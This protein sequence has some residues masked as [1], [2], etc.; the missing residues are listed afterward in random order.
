M[1]L[2]KINGTTAVVF[3]LTVLVGTTL[4]AA[5]TA[6]TPPQKPLDLKPR[7]IADDKTVEYDYDIV[8]VRAPRFVKG[9]D[10]KQQPAEVWPGTGHPFNLCTATDLMLLHPDGSEEVLVA[11]GKGAIADSYVSFDA[12]WVYYTYF[13]DPSLNGPERCGGAD[14]YKVHVKTRKVVRLTQQ[15]FT[16]NTGVADWSADYQ[17]PEK[18]KTHLVQRVINMNPCPLPGGRLA[19]VS[20]RDGFKTPRGSMHEAL[21]LFVMDD[22]GTNVEKIG[23]LNVAGALHPVVLKDGRLIFSSFE[24]MGMRGYGG[25]SSRFAGFWGLW[26]IHPDG[27]NWAPLV[28][29]YRNPTSPKTANH[30][31]TQL[32]DGSVV[33]GNYYELGWTGFGTYLKVPPQAPEGVP[34]FGPAKPAKTTAG[35]TYWR[36]GTSGT[37]LLTPFNHGLVG[38]A[39]AKTGHVTHPCGAPDNHLLTVWSPGGPFELFNVNGLHGGIYLIKNGQ[40]VW[41]PGAMLLIKHDPN[42]HAQWPRPLV[43]YKRV[44]GVDEPQRLADQRNDGKLSKHLPEGTPFGLVGSSSMYK[45]ESF[46]EGQV[47]EGSVTATGD[48]YAVFPSSASPPGTRSM[49]W[50][51]QNGLGRLN[52]QHQGADAGLYTNSDIHAIRILALEPA[53]I[54][55][56][57]KFFNRAGERLR[58]LGEIPVRKFKGEPGRVSAGRQP[59]DPDGNPD[60]S[61]LARIP[62]DMAWTFQT[63]DKDGMVLNMAQTWHQL[64]PGEIRTNCGGCHAHSQKPTLFEDTAAAR[65]DYPVFDLTKSTPLLTAKKNDQSGKKWDTQDTTGLRFVQGVHNVEYYRDIQPIFE[66]SCVACHSGKSAQPAV[67]LILDD[68]KPVGGTSAGPLPATYRTLNRSN[69]RMEAEDTLDTNAKVYIWHFRS[70]NSPLVWKIFGR[71]TDGLPEKS[72]PVPDGAAKHKRILDLEGDFKG[73]IMPPPEAVAGT[74]EGP[75]GKK[76]K[77][78]PLTDEDRR[79]IVRWIDLGSPIDRDYDPKNPQKLGR[80]WMLDDQRPTLT[81]TYPKVGVNEPLKRLLVGMHDYGTGLDLDSFKVVADFSIDGVPAGENLAKKFKVLP[82]S[83]WELQLERPITELLRGKL[84]VSVKDKQGNVTSIA[85]TFSV[86]PPTTGR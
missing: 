61:F 64:R 6:D 5:E 47:L 2:A 22:E 49:P 62:A 58:I 54:P 42:Y 69:Q 39:S 82:D 41:E 13:H 38:P 26:S 23:H 67:N 10:G 73:S 65:P 78:A 35:E 4:L 24:S 45:R 40:P 43:P 16:P 15:Q 85:R 37:E 9:N 76:I 8:Y 21:Q 79:M 75:D 14:I 50:G 28:S 57:G 30:F 66:R 55:V 18:G 63:L 74:Y 1:L 60:T 77:V 12:A 46:P 27:T 3:G 53:S 17:T 33:V 20:N 72:L 84:T 19:F 80:G 81:L 83:R 70:R 32:S 7:P 51:W 48:P 52:W 86:R 34:A 36:F 68:N 71:R 44:Y 25:P 59:L 31:Q 56:A 11:G 29:A